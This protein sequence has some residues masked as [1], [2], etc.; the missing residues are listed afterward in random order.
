MNPHDTLKL[1]TGNIAESCRVKQQVS[2]T[3][4]GDIAGAAV[5]IAEALRGGAKLLV[6]G[7][8]GSAAD[9]QHL[10]AELMG[11]FQKDRAPY[12][13]VALTTD[14]SIL[15]SVG[16]DYGFDSVFERQVLGLGR[17]GDVLAGITTSGNSPN[18]LAAMQA[19]RKK[20][21]K[22]IGITG[23]GGGKLAGFADLL[24]AVPSRTTAR[25]QEAH[26]TIIHLICELVENMLM[27]EA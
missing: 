22:T 17:A 3:M 2:E 11:R 14:T 27:E 6:C 12:A 13:A 9:A 26:I 1:I 23:L 15:T 4:A 18:V 7:N 19:A 25:I 21:L 16:N 10:A 20:D 5:M 8:G 24:L